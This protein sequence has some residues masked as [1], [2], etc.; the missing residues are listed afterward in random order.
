MQ[1]KPQLLVCWSIVGD[2]WKNLTTVCEL[3]PEKTTAQQLAPLSA[4]RLP[5]LA[6]LLL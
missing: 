2:V 5:H 3:N 4:F 6:S 1:L